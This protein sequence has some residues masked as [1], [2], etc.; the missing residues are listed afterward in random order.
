MSNAGSAD[1]APRATTPRGQLLLLFGY[2]LV[3]W[4]IGNGLLPLLPIIASDMGA[5]KVLVGV[6]LAGSYVALALGTTAAG[7]IS[8][9]LGHRKG[10]MVGASLAGAPLILLVSQA[11]ALWQLALLTASAW[12]MAGMALTMATIE[13]GR[14]AGPGQRGS[15]LGFLAMAAPLGSIAG[16]FGVGVLANAVGYPTMWL[17]LGLVWLLCPLLAL[18]VREP[19]SEPA[20]G[21][22][23]SAVAPV[24]WTLPFS[25]LVACG[26][27]AATG[28]FIGGFGRSFAMKGTFDPAAIT[29]TVAVSGI[30]A[31]PF[32]AIM[33][34]LSDRRGRLPFMA[35]CYAAGAAG[36]VVYSVATTLDMF[37]LAASLVAFISYVSTGVGSAL[38]VDLVDRPALG[39][40]LSYFGATGWIGAIL[41][42]GPGSLVFALYGLPTGFLL[43]AA[44]TAAGILFLAAIAVTPKSPRT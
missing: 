10:I 9:R 6:Y 13:A 5:D 21:G 27:L 22:P 28:S 23:A 42:F 3:T 24:R 16:G 4:S 2:A 30:V 37:W 38:V 7:F 40:G 41:A 32:A 1:A 25:L 34:W 14:V 11:A 31:F 36:L 35:L 8:D 39:R 12:C 26:I 33:G 18:F 17:L 44:I 29:S 43:G 19:P 20:A 15:I